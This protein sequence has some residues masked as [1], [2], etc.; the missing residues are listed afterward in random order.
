MYYQNT[1]GLRTKTSDFLQSTCTLDYDFI[2]ISETWL[3]SNFH[4]SELFSPEY[5]VYRNDR[6]PLVSGKQRGGGVMVG[7]L[8]K[9]KSR[10]ISEWMGVGVIEDIWVAVEL[11]DG[12]SW[13]L[14]CIYI[15]PHTMFDDFVEYFNKLELIFLKYPKHKFVIVGD[16]NIPD[17]LWNFDS[18]HDAYIPYSH[19]DLLSDLFVNNFSLLELRQFNGI[20]NIND[21]ILDLVA[22][23]D[24][25][26]NVMRCDTPFVPEDSHHVALE[27]N[28]DLPLRKQLSGSSYHKYNFD[29][30]NF[31]EI[32]LFLDGISWEEVFSVD[33]V[34][35]C[36]DIFYQIIH[37]VIDSHVP[38]KHIKK[39]QF[40]LWFSLKSIAILKEKNKFHKRWKK[41]KNPLDY[42]Q[43]SLLR[44]RSKYSIAADYKLYI[45]KTE[46]SLK[47]DTKYFWSYLNNTR[48]IKSFPS[49]LHYGN[50]QASSA[51][52]ISNL[53]ADYFASVYESN[54]TPCLLERTYS[55]NCFTIN[56][57]SRQ[58]ISNVLESIDARKGPGPDGIP[59]V[60]LKN[61][62]SSLVEPL[63]LLFNK[64]LSFGIFPSVWKE[65]QLIPIHKG[66]DRH[67]VCNYRPISILNNFG[68]VFEAVIANELT[69]LIRNYLSINQH[70]FYGG[71]SVLTN[72]V[73][74]VQ[75]IRFLLESGQSVSAVYTDFSKAFDKLHHPTL[76]VKLENFGV[77]GRLLN[78]LSDYLS[79]REQYVALNGSKSKSLLVRSGV[80]QG[81]HLGPILF[82]IFIND[83]GKCFQSCS[84]CLYADDLKLYLPVRS[85][86]DF[87]AIQD[88][89]NL[90]S[91]YC[92][93]NRLH[94]NLDKCQHILFSRQIDPPAVNLFFQ[95]NPI[96]TVTLVKDLG[97]LLDSKLSFVNHIE[98]IVRRAWRN[99]GFILRVTKDFRHHSSLI[100][101]F[102]SIVRPILEYATTVW[103]PGYKKYIE[104]I[105]KIQKKFINV[106]NY[107]FNR[108]RHFDS[109]SSNLSFYKICSLDKRREYFDIMFIYKIFNNVTDSP[110]CLNFI[111][112][113]V[114]KYST[115]SN[116]TFYVHSSSTNY[117]LNSPL[118]RCMRTVN[119]ICSTHPNI[120][121][122]FL[123]LAT[124][125]SKIKF[126]LFH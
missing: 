27:I 113:A 4:N 116:L 77:H 91:S 97:I 67:N 31:V 9:F 96:A 42:C 7:V 57:V 92:T 40:P 85:N 74:Y 19:G 111:N 13:F 44:K 108:Y 109:Y 48:K 69:H 36:T 10:V 50:V 11:Q 114:P 80:P 73:P 120:D 87:V 17:I 1:R 41:Y 81:S 118:L 65:A 100:T 46:D 125:K 104:Q 82:N 59:S 37:N 94:L 98:D 70:G 62:S 124:F 63:Y 86:V 2:C 121:L 49:E 12:V 122:F 20:R 35:K 101:L 54:T 83:I 24:L 8:N 51:D 119:T 107:R 58:Q 106:L 56:S 75:D 21:R 126:L 112:L 110:Y 71:R 28:F 117:Y 55:S 16:F 90:F 102:L 64:S 25:Q 66:G 45:G 84:F 76:L 39:K 3:N 79:C 93:T 43:F 23:R 61:C 99:L 30:A 22:S 89:L 53:F 72:L 47:S 26:L 103:N 105:E 115:R 52:S 18:V 95:N 32:N 14:C 6:D 78:L 60:F 33:D 34:N 68:K 15:P 123:R 88:D 38:I 29:N 5:S